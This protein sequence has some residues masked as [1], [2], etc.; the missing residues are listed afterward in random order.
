[1]KE[2]EIILGGQVFASKS[3]LSVW[4]KNL[5]K[6]SK[7]PKLLR[8]TNFDIIC[9]LILYHPKAAEKIGCGINKIW[10]QQ[11]PSLHSG[12]RFIIERADGSFCDFSYKYCLG[13]ELPSHALQVR[14]T[15]RNEVRP[16]IMVYREKYFAKY[17]DINGYCAC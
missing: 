8:D 5:L 4:I 6:N 3:A 15:M 17:R 16:Y 13:K 7:T 2:N 10:I 9:D 14:E 12:N 11:N 1:M